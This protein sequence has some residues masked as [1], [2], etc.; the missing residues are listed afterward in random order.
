MRI[1]VKQPGHF[2]LC[3]QDDVWHLLKMFYMTKEI[4]VPMNNFGHLTTTNAYNYVCAYPPNTYM[5]VHILVF[6][7]CKHRQNSLI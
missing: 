5:H 3:T 4:I 1:R 7:L 6:F 2:F